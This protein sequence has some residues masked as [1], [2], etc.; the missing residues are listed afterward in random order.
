MESMAMPEGFV[1]DVLVVAFTM[2]MVVGKPCPWPWLWR[3]SPPI[4]HGQLAVHAL[5]SLASMP[6]LFLA[7]SAGQ[8]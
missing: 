1:V 6:R 7:S 3:G 8:D 4:L 5:I 2:G